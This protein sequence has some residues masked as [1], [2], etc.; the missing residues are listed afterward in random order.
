MLTTM[1]ELAGRI[2]RLHASPTHP[3]WLD[4]LRV[5]VS[6][7]TSAGMGG[8]TRPVLALVAQGAKQTTLADRVYDYRAGQYLIAS[9]ELPVTG[10][11][12][13]ASAAEPFIGL[14]LPLRREVITELLLETGGGS[15]ADD[16]AGSGIVTADADEELLDAV[17]RLLRLLD[18][19]AD[20][21]V[22]G[23]GVE[24]EIHWHLMNG[25]RGA[26]VR[27]IGMEDSRVSLVGRATQWI[28][29]HFDR[30][31]RIADLA[32]E[33]GVSVATLNRHF[34]AVTAM[35]PLQYQKQL[36]LQQARLRLMA[37]P[38][39]VAAVGYAVGYDSPSQ[40]SREYRRLFGEPP[41]RDMHRIQEYTEV[42]A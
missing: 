1:R 17:V 33:I 14:G 36:R 42:G 2:A 5:N 16:D 39:D 31:I 40:F 4:G 18:R 34:R 12:T 38:D 13:R 7:T 3:V 9:L 37:A 35:S 23:P 28:S 29:R 22:L 15:R 41:G 24:R 30:T 6:T 10:R 25:P 19:P 27:R 8:L 32:D 26:A 20:F 21:T 11:I